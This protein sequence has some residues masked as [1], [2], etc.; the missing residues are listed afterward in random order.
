LPTV[1]QI[2]TVTRINN[3]KRNSI[4]AQRSSFGLREDVSK[5]K[6]PDLPPARFSPTSLPDRATLMEYL[7]FRK[8]ITPLIIQ[9]IFWL[10]IAAVAIV[11]LIQLISAMATG[12]G[13][14]IVAG[15]FGALIFFVLGAVTVRIYCELL[16]VAFRILDTLGEIKSQLE[17]K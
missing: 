1:C 13:L 15:L 12:S 10:G 9:I 8:M 17:K 4:L 11:C 5:F 14:I 3:V 7:V 6:A 16:I 2:P